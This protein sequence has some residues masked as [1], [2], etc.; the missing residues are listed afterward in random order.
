M[1]RVGLAL[2]I[3]LVCGCA[4]IPAEPEAVVSAALEAARKGDLE[5][6]TQNYV[7]AAAMDVRRA[8][9]AAEG[10]GWVPAEP[11]R[12]LTPGE[13]EEIQREGDRAVVEIRT[14]DTTTRV[15]LAPTDDGWRITLDDAV[16]DGDGWSCQP[17]QTIYA[18]AFG[19]DHAEEE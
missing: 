18:R 9:A 4:E 8:V 12:L 16:Q 10:S 15:C 14:S 19:G 1:I 11:L 6:L 7:P 17:H 2:L 13:V 5:G 3:L